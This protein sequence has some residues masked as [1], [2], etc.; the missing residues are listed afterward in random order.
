MYNSNE[1][2]KYRK[3]AEIPAVRAAILTLMLTLASLWNI[4]SFGFLLCICLLIDVRRIMVC[5]H[6][7]PMKALRITLRMHIG[8]IALWI[9]AVSIALAFV[10]GVRSLVAIP[11][12]IALSDITIIRGI[13]SLTAKWKILSDFLQSFIHARTNIDLTV[14]P[15]KWTTTEWLCSLVIVLSFILLLVAATTPNINPKEL[16]KAVHPTLYPQISR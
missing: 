14:Y 5:G 4:G 8:A 2:R 11:V 6:K 1:M 3:I 13:V 9:A 15:R 16:W 7:G 12:G 10:T